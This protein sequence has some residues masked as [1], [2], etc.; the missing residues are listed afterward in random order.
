MKVKTE[1]VGNEEFSGF[2]PTMWWFLTDNSEYIKAKSM[3]R[4]VLATVLWIEF[5]VN[6]IE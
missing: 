4:N 2:Q 5:K 3:N 6:I 1:S